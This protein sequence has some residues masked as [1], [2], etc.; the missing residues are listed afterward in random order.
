MER[1]ADE[2]AYFVGIAWR[3]QGYAFAKDVT[4]FQNL[5]GALTF[6]SGYTLDGVAFA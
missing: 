5:P 1:S 4:G 2:E 6:F 3:S